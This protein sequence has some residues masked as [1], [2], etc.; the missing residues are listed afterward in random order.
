M[1]LIL[2]V[3]LICHVIGDYYLQTQALSE[4]KEKEGK[5]LMRHALL[6]GLPF[7]LA[8]GIFRLDR[9]LII[10]GAFAVL[11]HG[12]IDVVRIVFQNRTRAARKPIGP[13]SVA[14][15]YLLD[16]LLHWLSLIAAAF[17]VRSYD[18]PQ[19]L[20]VLA[21]LARELDFSLHLGLQWL[22]AGLLIGRP[23][24][25]TFMKLF[26]VYRPFGEQETEETAPAGLIGRKERLKAGALIGILEKTIALL[27]L[28]LGEFMAIGLV[29][30]AKSIAR[31]DRI[32]KSPA[33]AEYYLIGTLVS[34]VMVLLIY[35]LSFR[36]L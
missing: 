16:Q 2:L 3:L 6:Y 19:P 26:S 12:V 8:G 28:S 18:M 23:S 35:I 17:L 7:L 30:T 31:Y 21:E 27:F 14:K 22:L 13:A 5:S 36:I 15:L 33:F 9:A 25:I 32:S 34:L 11:A 1:K 20:S 24:N 4:R 29:L 10:A